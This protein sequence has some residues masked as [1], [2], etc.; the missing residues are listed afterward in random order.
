MEE[1]VAVEQLIE[2]VTGYMVASTFVYFVP[3]IIAFGRKHPQTPY[4]FLITFFLGW[5]VIG[6]FFALFMAM[7]AA[8]RPRYSEL[9]DL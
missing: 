5:T 9:D 3:V 7:T 1:G 6:W 8:R 2:L 4:I